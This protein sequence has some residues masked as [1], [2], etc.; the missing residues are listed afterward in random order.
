MVETFKNYICDICSDQVAI[1]DSENIP[2]WTTKTDVGDLCPKCYSKW[3]KHVNAFL[4]ENLN[5]QV[6]D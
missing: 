2:S 3:V 4:K 5:E 1:S 6:H